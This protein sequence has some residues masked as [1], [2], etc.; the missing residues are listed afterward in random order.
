MEVSSN[1]SSRV[2][3][4]DWSPEVEGRGRPLKS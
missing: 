3:P 2:W 4:E 1:F